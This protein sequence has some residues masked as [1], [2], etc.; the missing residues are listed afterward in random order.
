MHIHF[1][2]SVANVLLGALVSTYTHQ[3]TAHL[4]QHMMPDLVTGSG[5]TTP[6]IRAV[7]FDLDGTLLDTESLSDRAMLESLPMSIMTEDSDI[8]AERMLLLWALKRQILG[9]RSSDWSE[10]V[11]QYTKTHWNVHEN[12]LPSA[13]KLASSWEENLNKLCGQVQACPGA[14][15]LV[16]KFAALGLPMAVAT[17]SQSASVDRKSKNHQQMFQH[18]A[19][20]VCGNHPAVKNGKPA[21]DIYLEAARQLGVAPNHCLAFEDALT[22]VRA[23]KAAGCVVV[24]VPD[25]RFDS[26]EMALFQSEADVV[27]RDLL[28]FSGERFGMKVEMESVNA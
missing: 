26:E 23:A 3:H 18:F 24:A 21:P 12:E 5:E 14:L 28:H 27:L 2:W 4:L 9:L 17:S 15:D 13:Q 7:I 25:Q 16:E 8:D 6:L 11:I 22:G 10:I 1:M 19:T 20:I